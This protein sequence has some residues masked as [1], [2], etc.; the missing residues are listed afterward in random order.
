[1]RFIGVPSNQVITG[2]IQ[3]AWDT[4]RSVEV[5]TAVGLPV[6]EALAAGFDS[7][8]LFV[9]IFHSTIF[10]FGRS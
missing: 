2:N 8:E 3:E 4:Y 10:F 6:E 1:M 9:N 7:H 5:V